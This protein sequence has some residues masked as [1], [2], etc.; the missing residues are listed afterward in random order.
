[1]RER[2]RPLASK[3]SRRAAALGLTLAVL[4]ACATDPATSGA[5]WRRSHP[6]TG[7]SLVR[8]VDWPGAT[9]RRIEADAHGFRTVLRFSGDDSDMGAFVQVEPADADPCKAVPYFIT[10][11]GAH[12]PDPST[13][14][15]TAFTDRGCTPMGTDVW[16]FGD[17]RDGDYVSYAERR[18][19]VLLILTTCDTWTHPPLMTIA[20]SLHP[21]TDRQLGSLLQ[22]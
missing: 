1:M 16:D 21:L 13:Y 10:D 7:R 19:G 11:T 18:D 3:G 2:S 14:G 4:S 22:G 12:H 5:V 20:A 9:V 6:G 17:D 15:H 8:T